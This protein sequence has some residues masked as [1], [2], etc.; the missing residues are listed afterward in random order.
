VALTVAQHSNLGIATDIDRQTTIISIYQALY[1]PFDKVCIIYEGEIVYF[2]LA[3]TD[4]SRTALEYAGVKP[5]L[6]VLVLD[7]RLSFL[8][9][10]IY[11]S[12]LRRPPPILLYDRWS[13]AAKAPSAEIAALLFSF[14]FSC[15]L[16]FDGV[17][18]PFRELHWWSWMYHLSPYTY[19]IEGLDRG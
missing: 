12:V 16:T 7:G 1:Q 19:L 5:I 15:V 14:L 18:Q 3:D 4:S 8:E 9:G 2:G 6:P 13:V 11:L 17:L 10:G